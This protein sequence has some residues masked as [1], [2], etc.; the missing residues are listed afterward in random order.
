MRLC[1]ANPE[2]PPSL[3]DE[4]AVANDLP[5]E[6]KLAA[7]TA[8]RLDALESL[9]AKLYADGRYALLIVLQGRDASGKDG[10]IREVFGAFNPQGCAVTSFKEP[11]PMERKHDFLWRIHCAAPQRGMVGVFNRSQYEDVV[12][13]RVHGTV[14]KPI[15]NSRYEQ[16]NDFERMLV[17]NNVVVLKFF[18][19]ISR[20][21]QRKRLL[22]RVEQPKKNWK[23]QEGDLEERKLWDDYTEAYTDMIRRCSTAEAPWYVVPSDNKPVRDYL[24]AGTVARTLKR[25]KLRYPEAD[26][27]ALLRAEQALCS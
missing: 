26:P 10:T 8:K 5:T 11:T 3:R 13:P 25:L 6:D 27:N 23:F 16:I 2:S 21:E 19:H 24:I 17:Q 15:I 1:P 7:K 20:A 18:L 9:Q 12:V 14:A 4:D 22:K